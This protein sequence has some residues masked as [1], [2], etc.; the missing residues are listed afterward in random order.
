MASQNC[1]LLANEP[2]SMFSRSFLFKDGFS[3][4]TLHKLEGIGNL[5]P[6]EGAG[7]LLQNWNLEI[8]SCKAE[9]TLLYSSNYYIATGKCYVI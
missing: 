2:P 4:S 1:S 7:L 8:F 6:T 3:V 9:F 5:E